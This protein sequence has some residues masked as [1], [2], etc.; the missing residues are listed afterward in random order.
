MKS[1]YLLG[2]GAAL[3]M[4]L[5]G[6][7]A[8]AQFAFLGGPYPV[9]YYIGPEGGW[10]QLTNQKDT[11]TTPAFTVNNGPALNTFQF[12]TK[13]D[14]GFNAGARA[15]VQWGPLRIEE[16]YSYRHSGLS[17]FGGAPTGNNNLFQ[18][19]RNA[20]ALMTNFI[21]DFTLGWPVSP[22]I[23]FG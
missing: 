6:A 12:N 17:N 1:R 9:A 4:A 7:Q 16:E 15:G 3:A 13:F 11:V 8:N 2:A 14:S 18:G 22:H 10:T 23:G 20:H 21:Y 19:N 5:G